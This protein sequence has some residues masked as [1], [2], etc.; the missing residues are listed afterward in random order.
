MLKHEQTHLGL[1]TTELSVA[2][3]KTLQ[4]NGELDVAAANNILDF[5]LGE[6]GVEAEL[7]NDT[8]V[9]PRRQSRVIFRLGTRH[10]HLARGEDK[11]GSLGVTDT[12]DDGGKTL[13]RQT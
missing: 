5:E 7:L 4:P 9:L 11:S 2:V 1:I 12:H 13:T 6:L 10:H 8:R 3:C